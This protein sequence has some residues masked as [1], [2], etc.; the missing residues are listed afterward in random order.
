MPLYRSHSVLGGSDE[1]DTDA[2]LEGNE[3]TALTALAGQVLT[4]SITRNPKWQHLLTLPQGSKEYQGL[5]M[6]H[7]HKEKTFGQ[8]IVGA[9]QAEHGTE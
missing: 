2:V 6:G 7:P 3:H 5:E 4:C 8:V 9:I 1:Q